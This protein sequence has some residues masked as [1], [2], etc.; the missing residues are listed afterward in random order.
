MPLLPNASIK[1]KQMFIIMLTSTVALLLACFAFVG[2]EMVTFR[3]ELTHRL[4]G[5][6]EHIADSNTGNLTF[7]D[8][9]AA[10]Q[11]LTNI[12]RNEKNIAFAALYDKTSQ[13]FA[14]YNRP[15]EKRVIPAKPPLYGVYFEFSHVTVC[16]RI[17]LA[18]EL[19]GAVVL[20]S[21]LQAMYD[22]LRQYGGIVAAVLLLSTLVALLLSLQ[23]Q[24][25]VSDPILLLVDTAKR[26]STEKN[27][28]VRAAKRSDD[29]LGNLIDS[30]NEM[31][32]QIQQRDG[33]LQTAHDDLE[34]RVEDRTRDLQ[35]QILE[36]MRAEKN[37]QQQFARI[38]LLNQITRAI[39]ERQDLNSILRVVLRELEENLP[40]DFGAVFLFRDDNETLVVAAT[41]AKAQPL[42]AGLQLRDNDVFSLSETGLSD[43]IQGRT[44]YAK[45]TAGIEE[46]VLKLLCDAGLQSAVAVPLMVDEKLFGVLL[47]ARRATDAFSSGECEF[48]RMLSDHVAV[49]AHQARLYEQLQGA[50]DELRQTQQAVMQQERLR[51]LGEMASGI[52]HDINNA[53]TPIVVYSE[54]V[55]RNDTS[56]NETTRR[57]LGNIKIAG[58]DIA[59]IVSRMR[60]FYRKRE[61]ADDLTAV[62]C[63]EL[64]RQV[65][66]L[67]RPR[68]RDIPLEKGIV[69]EMIAE[70]EPSLL[71]INANAPEFREA[72]TNLILNAVD[73]M[74]NGGN[75]VVRSRMEPSV[76][77]E[78]PR[79]VIEVSDS[80]IG[81]DDETRRR[82]LEPFFST[83]GQ[84]GTGLGLAMV[85]GIV[86]RHEG[87]IEIDSAVG[88]G[89]TM[90]LIFPARTAASTE[91]SSGETVTASSPLRILYIDDEPLLRDLLKETLECEG[92]TV[93]VAEHGQA[94][95]DAFRA[96]AKTEFPFDIVVTDLGMPYV[97]GRQVATI[98]KKD[99]PKTPV[100]LL[101]GWGQMMK[102]DGDQP[103]NVDAVISKPPRMTELRETLNRLAMK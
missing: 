87:R 60:E 38:S 25:V 63:N 40:I 101:T 48:F 51:A 37:L 70:L 100:V 1:R 57:H 18:G 95:I 13:V 20:E 34:K 83:K 41:R 103:A 59:H 55:L 54:L 97:D 6:A 79:V 58:E 39:S 10:R 3:Q 11:T 49:A 9:D 43:C 4:E 80:G 50:Y 31:L 102:S 96:A 61:Q 81:M 90:R 5:L 17:T 74:P 52:A 91:T 26:V 85:Y 45:E 56:L 65:I 89:T 19:A 15:D 71:Q 75:L 84:R 28:N 14:S 92:H 68:W 64:I 62:D 72:L 46:R 2:Y 47:G 21:D 86:E 22:R 77:N 94:G 12:L 29:E 36:R 44:L 98:L 53:L 73:A 7:E 93:S 35:L 16:H 27:Y 69:V 32:A 24:R 66:D 33:A 99:F 82:C 67:T 76:G 8:H 23:L 88:K 30:F 78:T 42:N